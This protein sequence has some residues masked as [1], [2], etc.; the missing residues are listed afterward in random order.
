MR[1]WL[2]AGV[3]M[4]L[5]VLAGLIGYTR[6]KARKLLTDL[7]HRLGIDIKSVTD[8]FTWSQSVK[9]HT[10][11]TIHAAKAIQRENGKTT[12]HDVAITLYGAPG[13]NRTDSISGAEFE[14][15]QPN[16]IVRAAGEVHLDLAAPTPSVNSVSDVK[17]ALQST[18]AADPKADAPK[19]IDESK[20]I[21]VTTSGLTFLQKEGIAQTDQPM[22][23]VYGDMRGSATGADYESNTGFLKL[24]SAVEMNGTQ[25]RQTVHLRAAA[26]EM[27]RTAQRATLHGAHITTD[28]DGAS[29]DLM[30][31]G[32]A[33][34]GGIE[35]V[36]AEGHAR[37]ESKDGM[38]AQA[39]KM[40]AQMSTAGKLHDVLMQGGVQFGNTSG[41][42]GNSNRATVHFDAQGVATSAEFDGGVQLD[43]ATAT[44]HRSVAAGHVVTLLAKDAAGH[45]FMREATATG[46]AIVRTS[47]LVAAEA[48]QP[49]TTQLTTL[50]GNT[51]HALT[52]QRNGATYVSE[53]T[54][55]G[56]TQLVQDDGAGTV[57]T[58]SGDD[59]H[60]TL[61]APPTKT[62]DQKTES[63][64]RSS[65]A[66]QVQT[67]VQTGH[68]VVT[69]RSPAKGTQP[70]G[71]TRATSARAEFDNATGGV[72][73]T[74]AP[75]VTS[76]LM[77]LA[78]DRIVLPQGSGDAE[79]TGSVRGVYL[80]ASAPSGKP[81]DP[82]HLLA[83]H[84][85]VSGGGSSAKLFGTPAKL[86]R[87]WTSTAQMEAPVIETERATGK[88]FAHAAG[89]EAGT[90]RMLLPVQAAPGKTASTATGSVRIT[91]TTLIYTP[92]DT[93]GPA[94]ADVSGGIRLD[95]PGTQLTAKS[96]VATI[97]GA[98]PAAART[99]SPLSGGN[100]QTVTAAGDVHLQQ[101]GRSGTG[102]RLVYTAADQR[103]ELTGTAAAPPQVQDSQ[104]GNVTG[105]V[106][107]FHGA[108]DS[109]EVS[110]EAGHRVR[111]EMEVAKPAKGR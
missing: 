51:L 82:V 89:A 8:G 77:Q 57:R 53:I 86:A 94:H 79:A 4:L 98:A 39:P 50:R 5:S 73:L 106:L 40:D 59:L 31:L 23:I 22:Q 92:A 38:T 88:L 65:P 81:A 36:H 44:A 64:P 78:A 90:V 41:A 32:M 47:E 107:V 48:G 110:G 101:P 55:T 1:R 45:S 19:P 104:R 83:D 29:G 105:A 80:A 61:A 25:N 109:V 70:A 91:G 27:D 100:I 87:M 9:G 52:A 15:D 60:A 37:L 26:A 102:E 63:V 96:A 76:P 43:Q 16:G 54:G 62:K 75:Q 17:S 69:Q 3:I 93:H 28:A 74:G 111:T 58:S 84:V 72:I 49:Q 35:S 99:A 21:R 67:A 33:K 14:Y 97:A 2:L 10:I 85:T 30:I 13:T 20:R 6:W 71:E 24:H 12:L 46:S 66:G 68:V 42:K 7:P 18:T 56:N 11:F 108:D 34:T 103:Y 95:S